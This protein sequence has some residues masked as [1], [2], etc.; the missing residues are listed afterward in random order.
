V[1]APPRADMPQMSRLAALLVIPLLGACT[2]QTFFV[3]AEDASGDT[4]TADSGDTGGPGL[5]AADAPAPDGSADT[6]EEDVPVD[7]GGDTAEPPDEGGDDSSGST[8]A[9]ADEGSTDTIDGDAQPDAADDA[10]DGDVP[11][12]AEI[13]DT[14]DDATVAPD[15]SDAL[16]T[17]D[18]ADAADAGADETG[19]VADVSDI[20][21]AGDTADGGDTPDVADAPDSADVRDASDVADIS[22][23]SDT[24]DSF[25]ADAP[26]VCGEDVTF[27]GQ[28][29]R[30]P[31]GGGELVVGTRPWSLIYPNGN[32]AAVV[33]E[34]P[35]G[36]SA[37]VL[38]A[39]IDVPVSRARVTATSFGT[40][41]NTTFWVADRN[42]AIQVFLGLPDATPPP[43][44]VAVGQE[45]AF[46]ATRVTWFNGRPQI[47]LATDMDLLDEGLQV[48]VDDSGRPIDASDVNT[49]RMVT[50]TLS[51]IIGSCGTSTCFD[52]RYGSNT[53]TLRTRSTLAEAG[54]CMTFVGPVLLFD[55]APQL[56]TV[57]F[58]WS[59]FY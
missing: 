8:D 14:A 12:D 4:A 41:S 26:L 45:I 3:P 35:S 28:I 42:A 10:V 18:A 46:T 36:S 32:L 6:S 5:D 43:F 25:E 51:R 22:D 47:T 15:S 24:T 27:T 48:A 57:N 20:S 50:G 23:T 54:G 39:D 44:D 31:P 21:D 38:S 53:I 33:A 34:V 7:D 37:D 9:D 52:L 11:A 40:S 17:P 59:W 2:E 19:D 55:G 29:G 56:D 1:T 49:M 16:D 58:D 13:A 30:L